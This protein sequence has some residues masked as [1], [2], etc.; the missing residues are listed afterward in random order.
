M[1][2]PR[3]PKLRCRLADDRRGATAL[4]FAL[5]CGP[6]LGFIVG[7]LC[8]GLQLLTVAT[9]DAVVAEAARQL[10]IGTISAASTGGADQNLR[11]M[12]C[13][14]LG[15]LAVSCNA[16]LK[17]YVNSASTFAALNPIPSPTPATFNP[18]APVSV[19]VVQVSCVSPF[20]VPLINLPGTLITSTAVYRSYQ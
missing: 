4:E 20:L 7:V 6:L 8:L 14:R 1:I 11:N 19:T 13:P 18:G 2:R 9:L 10:Q 5:L 12:I 15:G 17:I 3:F 16:N